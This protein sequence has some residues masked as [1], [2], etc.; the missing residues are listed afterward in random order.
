MGPELPTPDDFIIADKEVLKGLSKA[1]G[2][3]FDCPDRILVSTNNSRFVP[4]P[5]GSLAVFQLDSDLQAKI[6]N[7]TIMDS[8]FVD[9]S[10]DEWLYT[11]LADEQSS[12]EH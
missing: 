1:P 3:A 6:K 4:Q 12:L 9:L 2:L 8:I 7:F 5:S 10:D 11:L